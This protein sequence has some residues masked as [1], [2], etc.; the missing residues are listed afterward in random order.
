MNAVLKTEFP[1]LKLNS[2]GKVRDI[3]DLD[4]RL[5]IVSTDRISAFDCILANG[6]PGKGMVLN[7][8]SEFWFQQTRHLVR[9]HLVTTD[10]DAYPESLWPHREILR[11]RSML[12]DKADMIQVECVVRGYL[13]GSGWKE[14]RE[15]GKLAGIEMPKDLQ[16]ASR[17]PEPIFHPA[18]KVEN[19][20]DE[21]IRY[22]DLVERV[23]EKLAVHLRDVSVRLY[24]WAAKTIESRGIIIADT[25]FEFGLINGDLVLADEFLTPDS[26]RFW[27]RTDVRPGR[28]P[29][30]L[31]KQFVRDY[32]ETVKWDK[33]PPA[34]ALPDQ[35]VKET[36]DRY[37]EIFRLL[38]DREA[39]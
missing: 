12:V 35:I 32:L 26:S 16:V 14:Y 36:T 4:G 37:R 21:N 29:E 28:A 30:A 2:R 13:A 8:L 39:P 38:T 17:L 6:I 25:K 9:N 33:R 10:L 7:L 18:V 31:D 5:L 1:G 22:E 19:G 34:P 23:G 24:Q 20:H 15:T 27:R 11:N 3:Y